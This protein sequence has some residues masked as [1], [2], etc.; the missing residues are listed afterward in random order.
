MSSLKKEDKARLKREKKA[1]KAAVKMEKRE[2]AVLVAEPGA[3][4]AV[5]YAELVRGVLLI[6][7]GSSLMAALALGQQGMVVSLDDVIENLFAVRAGQ[8]GSGFDCFGVGDLRTQVPTLGALNK[9]S[10]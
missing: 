8:V 9:N 7:T 2:G 5:R 10:R 3:S 4:P 1:A 6:V